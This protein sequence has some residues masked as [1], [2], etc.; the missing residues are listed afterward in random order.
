M[1][2][3][4][5]SLWHRRQQISHRLWGGNLS[6]P[7]GVYVTTSDQEL[8]PEFQSRSKNSLWPTFPWEF[9]VT[10]WW[11]E[12]HK[13][14]ASPAT[15][16][17]WAQSP[18]CAQCQCKLPLRVWAM[19]LPHFL[20]GM[21]TREAFPLQRDLCSWQA[22]N[23]WKNRNQACQRCHQDTESKNRREEPALAPA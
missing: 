11:H 10:Q 19:R 23:S 1:P 9:C 4:G 8:F 7:G 20:K 16:C 12:C 3:P 5:S 6:V 21:D 14:L 13:M 22:R 2:W 17:A 15:H 18:Q